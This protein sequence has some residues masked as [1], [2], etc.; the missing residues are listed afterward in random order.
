[1]DILFWKSW[2]FYPAPAWPISRSVSNKGTQNER[3]LGCGP[4][5]STR[6][7]FGTGKPE[8][9]RLEHFIPLCGVPMKSAT[10]KD[11]I[12]LEKR[13]NFSEY[14]SC[15]EWWFHPLSLTIMCSL[16]GTIFWAGNIKK[17]ISQTV[18]RLGQTPTPPEFCNAKRTPPLQFWYVP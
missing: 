9:F 2:F 3:A 7:E 14:S 15:N 16:L 1:M 18:T 10:G 12:F 8:D 5:H 17:S 4:F 13:K 6:Y 11:A